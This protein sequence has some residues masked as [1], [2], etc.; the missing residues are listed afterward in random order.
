MFEESLAVFQDSKWTVYFCWLLLGITGG[1]SGGLFFSPQLTSPWWVLPAYITGVL[2]LNKAFAMIVRR[3]FP[4]DFWWQVTPMFLATLLLACLTPGISL[5]TTRSIIVVPAVLVGS[6]VIGLVHSIF[7]VVF[8]RDMLAWVYAATACAL[9]T[10]IIGWLL[11]RPESSLSSAA[12]VGAIVGFVYPVLTTLILELMWDISRSQSNFG[13]I[14][15]DKG[16]DF[17]EA[18][19]LHE[20]AIA[21]EPNNPKLYAARA[22][23]YIKQ[24][25][26]NRARADIAHA[27]TLD[28]KCAEARLLRAVLMAD[29][30][31]LDGA[32]AEYDQIVD[33]GWFY[34]DAYIHRARAYSLKGDYDRALADY[35]M[36]SKVGEDAVL[37]FAHR[38]ETYFQMGDYDRAIGECDMILSKQT[39]TPIAWT[40]ARL[41]RGKSY[42]AKGEDDLAE[43]NFLEALRSEPSNSKLIK[44]AEDGLRALESKAQHDSPQ[45]PRDS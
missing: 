20:Q 43:A 6:F 37:T 4:P 28:P 18:L 9:I 36:A 10:A 5:L 13:T 33:Y 40:M 41:T 7:R 22:D 29:E 11:F 31:D 35:D 15:A 32:I 42:A 45:S 30:G 26:L 21:L 19:D 3:I 23:V 39:F 38:A 17:E 16:G 25:E 14:L 27:L 8:V 1:L 12:V 24:D 2:A 44:E 34:Q